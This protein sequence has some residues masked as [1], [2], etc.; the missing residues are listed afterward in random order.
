M[1]HWR[2]ELQGVSPDVAG[3][4]T[5]AFE[6]QQ[7]A[8]IHAEARTAGVDLRFSCRSGGCGICAARLLAGQVEYV[9]SVSAPRLASHPADTVFLCQATPV[10]DCLFAA[11]W[12]FSVRDRAPLSRRAVS[13]QKKDKEE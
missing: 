2:V 13:Q 8:A 10:S 5:V 4:R 9:S 3:E 12:H 6:C 11:D 7:G 1:K